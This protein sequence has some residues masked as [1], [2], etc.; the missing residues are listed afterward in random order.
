M[1]D[2]N[3]ISKIAIEKMPEN[4]VNSFPPVSDFK[5]VNTKKRPSKKVKLLIFIAI[6]MLLTLTTLYFLGKKAP[7]SDIPT[8]EEK[9]NNIQENVNQTNELGLPS[10]E[11]QLDLMK[12]N[13]QD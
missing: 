3:T 7:V 13:A 4:S 10:K 1:E 8:V 9:L 11:T 6:I 5:F 12:L 2:N